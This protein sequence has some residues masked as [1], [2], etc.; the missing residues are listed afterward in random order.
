MQLGPFMRRRMW[1]P[2]GQEE[3]K[4]IFSNR[5]Y[6]WNADVAERQWQK[7]SGRKA[8]YKT[9]CANGDRRE[10][11]PYKRDVATANTEPAF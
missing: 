8:W 4:A 5:A 7:G 10:L 1:Q 2:S 9:I 3:L 6:R 11:G